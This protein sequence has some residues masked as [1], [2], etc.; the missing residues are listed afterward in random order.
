[1]RA[2][3]AAPTTTDRADVRAC[4]TVPSGPRAGVHRGGLIVTTPYGRTHLATQS[5]ARAQAIRTAGLR[6]GDADKIRATSAGPGSTT[7]LLVNALSL[8]AVQCGLS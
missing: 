3:G 7:T 8:T 1:M 4:Q 5:V 2:S 6:P